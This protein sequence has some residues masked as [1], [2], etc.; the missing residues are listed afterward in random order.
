MKTLLCFGDSN[1]HGTQPMRSLDDA[2]RFGPAER[3][4]GV[5]Q[6]LLGAPWRV[7]EEGLPGRT[8]GREDPVEGADRHA[9]HTLPA[10]LQSHRPLDAVV[11]M[12]GTNDLKAR[13]GYGSGYGGGDPGASG[14]PGAAQIAAGAHALVD[15]VWQNTLPGQARPWVLLV[16]PPPIREH[17]VLADMFNGGE[18]PGRALAAAL[19]TVAAARQVGFLDAGAHIGM[20]DIDGIHFDAAAHRRLGE[21]VA[22]VVVAQA[23]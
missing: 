1:T 7:I 3:W 2:R 21:A 6:A 4:P 13:F 15:T 18:A 23:G 8:L 9:L 10:C 11:F 22:A 14:S 19:R 20:S 12:L 5:L 16:S 17:G